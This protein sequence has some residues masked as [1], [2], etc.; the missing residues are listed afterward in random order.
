[1]WHDFAEPKKET[2]E[3]KQVSQKVIL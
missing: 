2:G 1:M 3:M